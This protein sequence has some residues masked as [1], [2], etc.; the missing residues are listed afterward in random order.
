[1]GY[2][3]TLSY[4]KATGMSRWLLDF[5]TCRE[6]LLKYQYRLVPTR[7]GFFAS[8]GIWRATS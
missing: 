6:L 1:M 3:C 4:A 5:V 2:F 7:T 8:Q